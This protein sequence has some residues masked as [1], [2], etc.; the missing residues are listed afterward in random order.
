VAPAVVPWLHAA[1]RA[2][3]PADGALAQALTARP[4]SDPVAQFYRARNY[5]PLWTAG[6]VVS[7]EAGRAIALLRAAG[8]DGL[9]PA[10]F[11]PDTV[12]AAVSA[13][14]SRSPAALDRA[15]LALSDAVSAYAVALH[16]PPAGA[17]LGFADPGVALP[18]ADPRAALEA[19]ARAPSL[20]AALADL[21]RMNPIYTQLRAALAATPSGPQADLL[22]LNLDRARAL[23]PDLGPR[24]ILVNPA[25]QTLWLY[26]Q[27][28]VADEMRV[29]VGKPS[30]P[31]PSL[32]GL[33]RYAVL[34][35]YWNVPPDLA[36]GVAQKVLAQGPGYLDAH[37]LQPLSGWT[38]D[39]AVV[40][41]EAVDWQAVADGRQTLHLRQ[42]PGPDNMMGRLKF[43]LPNPL[44]VYLHDTPNKALFASQRRTDSAGCVRLAD[45]AELG[46][47]LFGRM[48]AADPAAGPEQRVELASPV[49]VYILYLTAQP[50]PTGMVFPSDIYGRDP[51]LRRVT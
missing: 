42:L 21:Q 37:H 23:P 33:I 6:G 16:T 18:P 29:V 46:E 44:G 17:A 15:E 39:A 3:P 35:P 45:A 41:A 38:A 34:D 31:T 51:A 4:P 7:P 5:A 9:D 1:T 11:H 30:E 2:G 10:A 14:A 32:I 36:R 25:L 22:R 28:R 13:A 43:M 47:R 40:P 50:T 27:G 24:Y 20:A 19:I 49:P 26:D 48:L 8:A 12:A